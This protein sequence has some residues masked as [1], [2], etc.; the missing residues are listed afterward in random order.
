MNSR[1]GG[2]PARVRVILAGSI[3]LLAVAFMAL[4]V[5]QLERREWKHAL[6]HAVETRAY[7]AP[8]P[9]PGPNA[10]SDLSAD[11]SAYRRVH[12]TGRF[13]P[14]RDTFV[15]GVTGLGSG[16]WVLT[17]LQTSD[18][19]VLVNRGFVPNDARDE[20]RA[21]GT[22]PVTVTGLLRMTEPDGGFLRDNDPASGRWYSRDVAAIGEAQRLGG[23]APYFIDADRDAGVTGFPVGGLTVLRFSDNHLVYALTWFGLALFS[24]WAFWRLLRADAEPPGEA[25]L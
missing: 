9:A 2:R 5:W 13:L 14:E 12:V 16:Y 23:L 19:S 20:T 21:A 7:G 18:F 3:L 1:R 10:W 4:G 6:V 24:V 22:A 11:K 15:R 25:S 17:P 8:I